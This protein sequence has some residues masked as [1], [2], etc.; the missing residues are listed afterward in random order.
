[1]VDGDNAFSREIVDR[2]TAYT[3]PPGCFPH[4]NH[5]RIY[6]RNRRLFRSFP[7][8]AFVENL[9]FV[10]LIVVV[11]VAFTTAIFAGGSGG[12]EFLTAGTANAGSV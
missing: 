12:R 7:F 11:L 8:V 4:G 9:G 1:V 3:Q 2:L 5:I 6:R 10:A